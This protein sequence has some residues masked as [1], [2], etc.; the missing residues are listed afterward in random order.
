MTRRKD[1]DDLLANWPFQP[2]DVMARLVKA[3]DGREVLQMRVDMGLLQM[4]VEG[5]PDGSRPEGAETYFDYLLSKVISEGDGFMLNAP[6][7]AEVDREFV[8][9][10]HRRI[11]WLAL[12]KFRRAMKDA[13]HTLALMDFVKQ[14]SPDEQWTLSHEQYRPF[15]LFHRVEAAALA[16]LEDRGP[17][18]AIGEINHGLDRFRQIFEEYE[19]REKFDEDELVRRLLELQ[20]SL[21]EHYQ[22]DR[23]LDERLAEAVAS[24][25]Y[26]LAA[27][28]RDEIARR[29]TQSH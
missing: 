17:E 16:E 25:Q 5:R 14:H 11:C 2:G 24:E 21:R 9:F 22:V 27:Q 12:R 7:C 18:A 1:I 28:L 3:A 20:K 6:Q 4:E 29:Q 26:E 19:V 23:T 15:V 10:Y 13:D 8:Q